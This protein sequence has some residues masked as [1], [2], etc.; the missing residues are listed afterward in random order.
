MKPF[1]EWGAAE[2][3]DYIR[4]NNYQGS[5]SWGVGTAYDAILG[6]LDGLECKHPECPLKKSAPAKRL[7]GG[8]QGAAV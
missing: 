1:K 8:E 4:R 3:A 6:F 5:T 2:W 7:T